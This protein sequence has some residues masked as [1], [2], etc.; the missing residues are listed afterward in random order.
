MTINRYFP[1][2]EKVE[3]LGVG[4]LTP[5]LMLFLAS[6]KTVNCLDSKLQ[7]QETILSGHHY[8]ALTELTVEGI[9]LLCAGYSKGVTIRNLSR[10]DRDKEI[11]FSSLSLGTQVD[12]LGL[13]KPREAS[14]EDLEQKIVAAH[15]GYGLVAVPM[16]IFPAINED[17]SIN[18]YPQFTVERK[19]DDETLVVKVIDNTLYCAKGRKLYE[20]ELSGTF[21]MELDSGLHIT[22]FAFEPQSG[23]I[24]LGTREGQLF[25]R[26]KN[27]PRVHSVQE[28]GGKGPIINVIVLPKRVLY[29]DG[30]HPV[31][32]QNDRALAREE[33]VS[34]QP[35]LTS[36]PSSVVIQ[37]SSL[38]IQETN[39]FSHYALSTMNLLNRTAPWPRP[40]R[41]TLI[42][43]R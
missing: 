39:H 42:T 34:L 2:L 3:R 18:D 25:R 5:P 23:D 15:N 12:Y 28:S 22:C 24:Y 29:T 4:E 17:L 21:R 27:D 41:A 13:L 19:E 1:H 16:R 35:G 40:I 38:F 31:L 6:D 8:T 14:G 11:L 9:P 30:Q 36:V 26:N 37:D 10:R 7:Y 43:R 20:P 33:R 32:Y